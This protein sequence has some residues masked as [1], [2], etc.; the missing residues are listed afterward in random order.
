MARREWVW[1]WVVWSREWK[2]RLDVRVKEKKPWM[3]QVLVGITKCPGIHVEVVKTE[4]ADFW[5]VKATEVVLFWS[6]FI[7][8]SA[9]QLC[10]MSS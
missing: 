1:K 4:E 2:G 6:C 9:L 5:R 10:G 7:C 8:G 3:T